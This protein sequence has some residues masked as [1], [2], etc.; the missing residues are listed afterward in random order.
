MPI[1][2]TATDAETRSNQLEAL[3]KEL[4][5]IPDKSVAYLDASHSH[6]GNR[7]FGEYLIGEESISVQERIDLLGTDAALY[8][9]LA[10]DLR[11]FTNGIDL[12]DVEIK[13]ALPEGATLKFSADGSATYTAP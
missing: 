6:A 4:L 9:K 3:R 8:F 11:T 5:E 10:E 12:S 2:T 13:S 1:F 7:I